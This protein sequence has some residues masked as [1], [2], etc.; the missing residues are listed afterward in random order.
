MGAT[1]AQSLL[2]RD[3]KVTEHR[4]ELADPSLAP[5]VMAPVHPSS[6]LRAR[7]S[8]TGHAELEAF[9]RDLR[10]VAGDAP[11]RTP[12]DCQVGPRTAPRVSTPKPKRSIGSP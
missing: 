12:G 8:A 6:I 7:D 2:G 10:G 9:V 5:L 1:A 3:S 4:G 11:V